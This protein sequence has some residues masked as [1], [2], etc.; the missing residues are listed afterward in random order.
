MNLVDIASYRHI[1]L[2]SC[3]GTT[4]ERITLTQMKWYLEHYEIYLVSMTG[5][6]HGHSSIDNVVN[7]VT[8]VE[9]Q[10]ASKKLCAA[11]FLDVKGA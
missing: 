3:V 1:V 6:R 2:I 4:V 5:F 11:L 8:Y 7:L 10:K 9:H